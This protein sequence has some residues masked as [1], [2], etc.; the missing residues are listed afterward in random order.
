MKRIGLFDW[1]RTVAIIFIILY[2][3]T[4]QYADTI[5]HVANYP[6]NFPYGYMGVTIFF[7]LSGF[8][9]IYKLNYNNTNVGGVIFYK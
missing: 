5:G 4:T 3:Y 6:L 7:V 1:L 9:A 8:L 2:H